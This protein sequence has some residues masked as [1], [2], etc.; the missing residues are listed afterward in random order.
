MRIISEISPR[1]QIIFLWYKIEGRKGI[2]KESTHRWGGLE[3]QK[4]FYFRGLTSYETTT[5]SK[6]TD[7]NLNLFKTH[8][9][10]TTNKVEIFFGSFNKLFAVF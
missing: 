8:F 5:L 6:T 1:F 7:A 2:N 9:F 3:L 10:A 4:N